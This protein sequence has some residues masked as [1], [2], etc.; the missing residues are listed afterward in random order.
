[1]LP[2]FNQQPLYDTCDLSVPWVSLPNAGTLSRRPTEF[3]C[4]EITFA[5]ETSYLAVVG[6]QTAWPFEIATWYMD[7]TDGTSNTVML[8][9]LH[10]QVTPWTRPED[11]L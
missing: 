7:F 6:V 1:M 3:R 2:W 4:P 8:V 9:D 11:A 5:D 10:N